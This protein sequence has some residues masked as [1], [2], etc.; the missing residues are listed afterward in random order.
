MRLH[1]RLLQLSL[2]AMLAAASLGGARAQSVVRPTT[3]V[4]AVSNPILFV[5]QMPIAADFATIGA[6]FANH[7][8]DMQSVGR[9]GDLW[10][11]YPDGTLKNLTATAGYGSSDPTG[12]QGANA[13]AVRDPAVSWD[14]TKALFSMVVGA[15]T[16][17][18]EVK[19]FFWQL[20]EVSGLG[21]ARRR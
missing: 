5:T 17:Q 6:V 12:F 15:P 10:M 16:K 2:M 21:V 18:Y 4:A 8:A 20:Y 1:F 9:G 14:G 13:I 3:S 7:H 11:R 19:T